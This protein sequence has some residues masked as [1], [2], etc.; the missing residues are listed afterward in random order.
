[1]NAD[2]SSPTALL[3]G[4]TSVLGP[5]WSKDGS[6]LAFSK[7]VVNVNEDLF[8]VDKSG[9]GLQKI[10]NNSTSDRQASWSPDGRHLAF[11][12][13][14]L[15]GNRDIFTVE[16]VPGGTEVNV[17]NSAAF[18]MNPNWQ[19]VNV[20]PTDIS[21]VDN[22]LAEN[23]SVATEVGTFSTTDPNPGDTFTYTLVSGTGDQDNGQFTIVGHLLQSNAVFD[24]E[25]QNSYSV[26]VRATDQGGLFVEDTFAIS[27]GDVNEAPTI[28]SNGGGD[29][30]AVTV[31]ENTLAVTTVTASDPDAAQT[32]TFGFGGGAD[33]GKFTLDSSS[34]ALTFSTRPDFELP[35]DT[36]GNNVYEVVVEVKDS[37]GLVD[38]QDI[39][40]T[41]TDVAEGQT[42]YVNADFERFTA[43]D[44]IP[45][46]DPN[47]PGNQQVIYQVDAFANLQAGANAAQAGGT[48]LLTDTTAKPGNYSENI[49]IGKDLTI[50]ATSSSVDSVVVDGGGL[51]S[52]FAIAGATVALEGFVIQNG[53]AANGGGIWSDGPLTLNG[54]TIS[55]NGSTGEGGGGIFVKGNLSIVGGSITGNT[56][57]G[58]GG[59][60]GSAAPSDDSKITISGNAQITGNKT[61]G[62]GG[63]IFVDQG[64]DLNIN[65][66]NI[67]NNQQQGIYAQNAARPINIANATVNSNNDDGLFASVS[68]DVDIRFSTF[69]NNDADKNGSGDGVH[70]SDAS[71]VSGRS[72]ESKQM[73]VRTFTDSVFEN[74]Q[75]GKRLVGGQ[76]YVFK[77]VTARENADHG[78]WLTDIAGDVKL[79]NATLNNN[80]SDHNRQ[81]SGLFGTDGPDADRHSIGG[82]LVIVGLDARD[83]DGAGTGHSQDFGICICDRAAGSALLDGTT[84]FGITASFNLTAGVLI[85]ASD[86]TVKG[87]NYFANGDG[88]TL[89]ASGL[90]AI[91]DVTAINNERY[92]IWPRGGGVTVTNTTATANG[93]FGIFTDDATTTTIVSTTANDNGRTAAAFRRGGIGLFTS[94]S[95]SLTDVTANNNQG[96]DVFF[97]GLFFHD[98]RGTYACNTQHGMEIGSVSGNVTLS[99]T[100]LNNN[101]ADSSRNGHGLSVRDFDK[102]GVVIGGQ[103]VLNGV[104]AADTDGVGNAVHQNKG[105]FVGGRVVGG[106]ILDS[107]AHPITVAGHKSYGVEIGNSSVII[108]G[109]NYSNNGGEGS[110]LWDAAKNPPFSSEHVLQNVTVASNMGDGLHVG[111][112]KSVTIRNSRFDKNADGVQLKDISSTTTISNT[113]FQNNKES[114]VRLS[115]SGGTHS[116]LNV[117]AKSNAGDGLHVGR[118]KSVTIRNSRFDKN[119]DGVQLK[120]ISS[121]TAISNSTFQNNKETG[122]QLSGSGATHSLLNV[123]ADKNGNGLYASSTA[124]V[125]VKLSSFSENTSHGLHFGTLTGDVDLLGVSARNNA[126]DGVKVETAANSFKSS[127]GVF[128]KNTGVGIS[129]TSPGTV[130]LTNNSANSNQ[131]GAQVNSAASFTDTDGKYSLNKHHGIQL[132]DIGGAVTLNRTT[133]TANSNGFGL[134]MEDVTRASIDNSVFHENRIGAH[135]TSG[136]DVDI[137]KSTLTANQT[138]AQLVQ[139]RGSFDDVGGDYSGNDDHGIQVWDVLGDITVTGTKLQGNDRDKDGVGDGLTT[140][141]LDG[142]GIAV[143][144][145]L[146]ITA[147]VVEG[148]VGGPQRRGVFASGVKGNV[149]ISGSGALATGFSGHASHGVELDSIQGNIKFTGVSSGNQGHGLKVSNSSSLAVDSSTFK[150]NQASGV[151]V[152]KLAGGA[153][154]TNVVASENKLMG[155]EIASANTT[156]RG[157]AFS[158]NGA[159]GARLTGAGTSHALFT[160]SAQNNAKNGLDVVDAANV[161]VSSF[162]DFSN[163]LGSGMTLVNLSGML[164][165]ADVNANKNQGDGIFVDRAAT[166]QV[167]LRPNNTSSFNDNNDEG[168]DIRRVNGAVR[169]SRVTARGNNTGVTVSDAGSFNNFG[170]AY[171]QNDNHGIL[172]T[173]IQG[174]AILQR[175]T[176]ED[177]NADRDFVGDGLHARDGNDPDSVAIGGQLWVLGVQAADTDGAGSNRSQ[178]RGLFVDGVASSAVLQQWGRFS[179]ATPFTIAGHAGHGLDLRNVAGITQIGNLATTNNGGDG[180]SASGL[181]GNATFDTILAQ[182]NGGD[183]IDVNGAS[184]NVRIQGA[185]TKISGRLSGVGAPS[186]IRLSNVNAASINGGELTDY[187]VGVNAD[188]GNTS[189]GVTG[190]KIDLPM[191]RPN[192]YLAGPVGVW[193]QSGQGT[194]AV[195]AGATFTGALGSSPG[196]TAILL[197]RAG[198]TLI[199]GNTFNGL[200]HAVRIHSAHDPRTTDFHLTRNTFDQ[201]S[202]RANNP[203]VGMGIVITGTDNGGTASPERVRING[204]G[205]TGLENQFRGYDSTAPSRVF[206]YSVS[207]KDFATGMI[208][209]ADVDGLNNDWH[210]GADSPTRVQDMAYERGDSTLL[211]RMFVQSIDYGDAPAGG[212]A[213]NPPD[214]YPTRVADNGAGHLI[215]D[216][217]FHLGFRVD[218]EIDGQ[219]NADGTGDD[220]FGTDDEDGVRFF[221]PTLTAGTTTIVEVIA[222]IPASTTGVLDAWFDFNADGHWD[223]PVEQ[224]FTGQPL[225]NGVNRLPLT[226]ASTVTPGRSFARFRLS[227]AGGLAPTGL[228]PSGEVEDHPIQLQSLVV[229]PPR[230]RD[231][232]GRLHAGSARG[233]DH[234]S[235]NSASGEWSDVE[236]SATVP[237]WRETPETAEL[238]RD[239]Q[240]GTSNRDQL[241]ANLADAE[242]RESDELFTWPFSAEVGR[243]SLRESVLHD[244]D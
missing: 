8:I 52:V 89:S 7:G 135:I 169:L 9:T 96:R 79:E 210:T 232:V 27:V 132:I 66:A 38:T 213:G 137:T 188:T 51:G 92:G 85:K 231:I 139:T 21:L 13:V 54:A 186:A 171:Q 113:T 47:T 73:Q 71:V 103:L 70:L 202:V 212:A 221:S 25:T 161:F 41:V 124:A 16:A 120:D 28:T 122:V 106:V 211:G 121:T 128:D 115:G 95:A 173:D 10:T 242:G 240:E 45:D 59:G 131:H 56:T 42:V 61:T 2:G 134:F 216:A 136:G 192:G 108:D 225:V 148:T 34:R 205:T 37:Q 206:G 194:A 98:T 214:S 109:G 178:Q 241:F 163:N 24:F 81:G 18:E 165:V 63:G 123:T 4:T 75:V 48:V 74:N 160:V 104:T 49:S 117:S 179:S 116:L 167:N 222:S 57:T 142:D 197:D 6:K 129:L 138:G 77:N 196:H 189:L 155:V 244:R 102:D 76:S 5:A 35:A 187:Y 154:L 29:T 110:Y 84:P 151:H 207:L 220:R 164:A 72:F 201:R 90:V 78:I 12:R 141:D 39:A 23:L 88:L 19:P 111:R 157:G 228:A 32:L 174:Y 190:T 114:G 195:V 172:L 180:V 149:K 15:T 36:S 112:A 65:G 182:N 93:S 67:S 150:K 145:S 226:I 58:N 64:Y 26:R 198:D 230:I 133:L 146:T 55:N 204:G 217:G 183:G 100:T 152:D 94:G 53:S 236:S 86:V 224:V 185:G 144:G 239:L 219:P 175:T 215:A 44:V 229:L 60:V 87:G 191:L 218:D 200:N 143:G 14:G 101:D 82:N 130:T 153:A 11:E 235:H 147:A 170:G 233:A 91:A 209:T 162:S 140:R 40:V 125:S 107:S 126:G 118:A 159:N 62:N 181:T 105:L 1:M 31:P 208:S 193:V 177:N 46:A 80:D 97:Q 158:S 176:L 238:P 68:G 199:E 223:H 99:H 127:V 168:I 69:S 83:T 234:L 20:A 156:S 184:G 227:Q 243:L 17:T 237:S 3:P 30:A 22:T 50:R 203:Q 166:V 43:G 33:D 119:S